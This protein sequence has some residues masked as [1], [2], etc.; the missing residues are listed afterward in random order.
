[1]E[2]LSWRVVGKTGSIRVGCP[3][4]RLPGTVRRKTE[5]FRFAVKSRFARGAWGEGRYGGGGVYYLVWA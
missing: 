4:H 5:H 3:R 2:R 1:M